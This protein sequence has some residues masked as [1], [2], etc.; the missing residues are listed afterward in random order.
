M[1][2]DNSFDCFSKAD[3]QSQNNALT[4]Q[5]ETSL[6]FTSEQ[7]QCISQS[8]STPSIFS[9]NNSPNSNNNNVNNNSNSNAQFRNNSYYITLNSSNINSV[10]KQVS[11]QKTVFFKPIQ[12]KPVS[13]HSP[14]INNQNSPVNYHVP[15]TSQAQVGLPTFL[16]AQNLKPQSEQ[17]NIKV[18]APKGTQRG[19]QV[20]RI[21]ITGDKMQQVIIILFQLAFADPNFLVNFVYLK[22]SLHNLL[23]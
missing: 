4:P 17:S 15:I 5:F 21:P 23:T 14:V 12:Q 19:G 22:L 20:V 3:S 11:Q 10:P 2:D 6:Q 13:N 7:S 8:D 9:Q 18:A 16:L 1:E